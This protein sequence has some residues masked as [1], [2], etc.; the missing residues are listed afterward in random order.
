ME[1]KIFHGESSSV[2]RELNSFLKTSGIIIKNIEM[3]TCAYGNA[4]CRT[5]VT[6]LIV[7]ERS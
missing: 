4:V 7:Y 2:E 1:S 3:S 5:M 6:V